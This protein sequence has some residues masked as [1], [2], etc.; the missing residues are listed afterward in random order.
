MG[1]EGL[2]FPLSSSLYILLFFFFFKKRRSVEDAGE[3]KCASLQEEFIQDLVFSGCGG[4]Q[5]LL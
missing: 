1:W 5:T 4:A 3:G 2:D